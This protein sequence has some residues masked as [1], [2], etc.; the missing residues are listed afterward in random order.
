MTISGFAASCLCIFVFLLFLSSDLFVSEHKIYLQSSLPP[1]FE[2]LRYY[3]SGPLFY[4]SLNM[5]LTIIITHTF[6]CSHP[7]TYMSL[8]A[9]IFDYKID[10][11]HF[12]VDFWLPFVFVGHALFASDITLFLPPV[13]ESVLSSYSYPRSYLSLILPCFCLLSLNLCFPP[14]PILGPMCL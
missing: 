5:A 3:F 2:S 13:S 8:S 7:W 6:S 11:K 1:A 12:S 4:L 9:Y 14:I 10:L